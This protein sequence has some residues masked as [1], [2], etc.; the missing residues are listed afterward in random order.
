MK[1]SNIPNK[2]TVGA[3]QLF[4][5]IRSTEK[6]KH[7]KQSPSIKTNTLIETSLSQHSNCFGGREILR[8]LTEY[9]LNEVFKIIYQ[10]ITLVEKKKKYHH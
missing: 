6:R 9:I 7:H 4:V 10:Q 5:I 1:H 8:K 3:L 2:K